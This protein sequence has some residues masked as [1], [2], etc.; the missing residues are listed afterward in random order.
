MDKDNKY[1]ETPFYRT[2]GLRFDGSRGP[3]GTNFTRNTTNGVVRGDAEVRGT[4]T[5][6]VL[7]EYKPNKKYI[8]GK[9]RK[10]TKRKGTKRK[11]T[12]RKGTRRKGTRRR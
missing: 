11:S 6:S 1:T 5:G 8:G 2:D 9:R 4:S 3:Y 7:K 10:G 12:K